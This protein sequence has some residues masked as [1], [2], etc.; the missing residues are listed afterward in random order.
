MSYRASGLRAWVWQRVSAVVLALFTLLV[1]GYFLSGGPSS[2]QDWHNL[3][4]QAPVTVMI[5]LS[6]GALLAHIWVGVRDIIIDYISRPW[7]RYI[8]LS[9]LALWLFSL[10][11]WVLLLLARIFA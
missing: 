3:L 7:L 4:A 10:G 1:I 9:L 11:L 8:L 2:Y 5:G 6:F